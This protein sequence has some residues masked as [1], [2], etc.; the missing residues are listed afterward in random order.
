MG[1]PTLNDSNS[2]AFADFISEQT[3]PLNISLVSFGV[4]SLVTNVPVDLDI[5]IAGDYIMEDSSLV[6][7]CSLSLPGRFRPSSPFV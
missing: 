6:D 4:V 3:L 2:S 7:C 5:M 1:K